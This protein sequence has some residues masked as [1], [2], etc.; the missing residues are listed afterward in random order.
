[1]SAGKPANSAVGPWVNHENGEK[2]L[3]SSRLER[4]AV[5]SST[6]QTSFSKTAWFKN[7]GHNATVKIPNTPSSTLLGEVRNKIKNIKLPAEFSVLPTSD[8]GKQ[9]KYQIIN[10]A[11]P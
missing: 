9:I 1:M 6:N 4:E 5:K 2:P 8:N 3:Y 11:N 7:M 10:S